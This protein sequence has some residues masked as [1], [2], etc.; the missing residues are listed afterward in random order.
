[1]A[2]C[3]IVNCCPPVIE[4]E[5]RSA[6]EFLEPLIENFVGWFNRYSRENMGSISKLFDVLGACLPGFH[7]IRIRESGETSFALKAVFLDSSGDPVEYGFDQLSDGQRA[8][9]VLYSLTLLANERVSLF[10]EPLAK[11]TEATRLERERAGR[12]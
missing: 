10:I 7:S 6:D 2:N 1:M 12:G 8:L 4:S 5:A 9:V 3:I 11:F